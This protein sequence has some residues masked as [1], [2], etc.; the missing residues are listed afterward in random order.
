MS[1]AGFA[2]ERAFWRRGLRTVAGVDEAGRGA[3][4]GPVVVA[5]VVLPDAAE[6]P[7]RDSKALSAA[8]RE[9]L[10]E[11]V[12]ANA[13]AWAVAEADAG[14]VDALGPLRATHAAAH[15]AIARLGV[16]PDAF[17]TDYLQLR[18]ETDAVPLVAPPR[19]DATSLSVAAASI[20]AKTHRD[21]CMRAASDAF[22]A[23][24]FE[25]HKGYGVPAHR[26]ALHAHG[27]CPLHR[28]SYRPVARC[29]PPRQGG[30]P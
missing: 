10:A 12:R 19:A 16:V 2:L 7:Y 15:R 8:M 20:L 1:A 17:V 24:G 21:A 14:E 13:L 4:A 28:T 22:P 26:A 23:Y 29:A 27:P 30:T 6:L 11:D 18:F 25:R 9:R 5:V 3:W